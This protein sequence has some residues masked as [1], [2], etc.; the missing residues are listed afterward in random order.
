MSKISYLAF[1]IYKRRI[2]SEGNMKILKAITL[3]VLI[4]SVSLV[5]ACQTDL[6]LNENDDTAQNLSASNIAAAYKN[7]AI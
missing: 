1:A 3:C 5:S 7:I 6:T 4:L 2:L